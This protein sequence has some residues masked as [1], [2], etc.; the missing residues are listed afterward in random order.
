M[1]DVAELAIS[2]MIKRGMVAAYT[3]NNPHV[4]RIEPPL[5]LKPSEAEW[6]VQV[7]DDAVAD[8]KEMVAG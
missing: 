7:F 8:T 3:L 1:D 5:I 2:Q 4:I 6:A